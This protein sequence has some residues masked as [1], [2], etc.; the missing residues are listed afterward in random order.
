[1]GQCQFMGIDRRVLGAFLSLAFFAGCGSDIPPGT[2]EG[3]P[4]SSDSV[5]QQDLRFFQTKDNLMQGSMGD[6]S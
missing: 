6:T 5:Y 1:M 4:R 3:A 2:I